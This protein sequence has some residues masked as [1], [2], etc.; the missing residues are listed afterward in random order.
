M[1]TCW[2]LRYKLSFYLVALC[3][4]WLCCSC[5][6]APYEAIRS[7]EIPHDCDIPVEWQGWYGCKETIV[8]RQ[9]SPSVA[10]QSRG[11]PQRRQL[12]ERI[13]AYEAALPEDLLQR[14]IGP[15]GNTNRL[16]KV[17]NKLMTGLPVSLSF[18][19]GSITEGGGVPFH[20]RAPLSFTGKVTNW[21]RD[22][23]PNASVRVQNAGVGGVTSLYY[24][25]CVDMFVPDEDVDLV[26][27][28]FTLN[29]RASGI[30]GKSPEPD[31]PDRRGYEMLLRKL[32]GYRQHPAIIALHSWSPF[33]NH[34]NFFSTAEDPIQ[35]IVAY[36]GLQSVSM[37]NA[38][39]HP[40]W[41]RQQNY[42]GFQWL[43][44]NIH[45]N[46]LGHRYYADIIV[47]LLQDVALQAAL[48][49]YEESEASQFAIPPPMYDN[50]L[51]ST[52]T[53]LRGDLLQQ[54]V[55]Q[56]V[57]WNWV[58][59]GR[60]GRHKY[61]YVTEEPD[62]DII[63]VVNTAGCPDPSTMVTLGIGHLKSYERMGQALVSCVSGCVCNPTVFDGHNPASLASQEFWAYIAV[64]QSEQCV[65][66]V[67][68]LTATKSGQ[69]KVK[70]TS[71]LLTCMDP[72][73]APEIPIFKQ[74]AATLGATVN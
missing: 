33:F 31:T 71:L 65:F 57:G 23:Y 54:R 53:C 22:T 46:T 2:S 44:D 12:A 55:Y 73:D 67:A 17:F 36:Y 47:G 11:A 1:Q 66:E 13:Y 63:F 25:Q 35:S 21:V 58:D 27:V 4:G 5:V 72:E 61:G 70:V 69:N 51:E 29:D 19:G 14:G 28:D 37:R 41:Q 10:V 39:F 68:S 59:E 24:A 40:T 38:L 6:A 62:H 42:K 45:P 43:C 3:L 74:T 52:T 49:P 15:P 64:S 48:H 20:D 30:M 60:D 34:P 7:D 26:F 50:N 18:I 8:T 56:A 32:L 16:L 9:R